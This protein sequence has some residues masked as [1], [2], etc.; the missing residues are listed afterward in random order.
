MAS[1]ETKQRETEFV[2]RYMIADEIQRRIGYSLQKGNGKK[3]GKFRSGITIV[4][5]K[6]IHSSF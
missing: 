2:Q 6:T 3:N 1:A 5:N 4:K